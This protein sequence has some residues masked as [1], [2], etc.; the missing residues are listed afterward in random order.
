MLFTEKLEDRNQQNKVNLNLFFNTFV[1]IDPQNFLC[2][3]HT[4]TH[5][6]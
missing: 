2:I 1:Y 5:I 6:H 4:C 3:I